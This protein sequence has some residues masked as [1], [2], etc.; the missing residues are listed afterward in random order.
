MMQRY[1]DLG[2]LIGIL[3]TVAHQYATL[4]LAALLAGDVI[5]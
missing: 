5:S 4:G 3:R 2:Y 1:K